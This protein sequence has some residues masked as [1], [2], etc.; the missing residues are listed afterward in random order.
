MFLP[1]KIMT[2]QNIVDFVEFSTW[3]NGLI[4]YSFRSRQYNQHSIPSDSMCVNKN[5]VLLGIDYLIE[6]KTRIR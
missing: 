1:K 5:T 2:V 6:D 4:T 3:L